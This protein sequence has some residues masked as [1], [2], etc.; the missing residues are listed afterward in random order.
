MLETPRARRNPSRASPGVRRWLASYPCRFTKSWASGKFGASSWARCT[1]S[2]VLPTPAIPAIAEMTTAAPRGPVPDT[3][4]RICA[5]SASRPVKSAMSA[6]SWN[7]VGSASLRTCVWRR[8]GS[9]A[10]S[11]RYAAS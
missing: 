7:G 8:R 2:A 6:G 5:C 1:A 11:S 10:W 4:A 3:S 9:S